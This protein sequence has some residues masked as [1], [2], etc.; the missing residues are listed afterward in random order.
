VKLRV[1]PG[2]ELGDGADGLSDE[3]YFPG[4]AATIHYR[5]RPTAQPEKTG[6]ALETVAKALKDALPTAHDSADIVIGSL[7]ILH[8]SVLENFSLV[9]PC[10]VLEINVEPFL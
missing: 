7:G 9:N 2:G 6:S 5:P 3:M 4:R 8:P 1:S 10:S